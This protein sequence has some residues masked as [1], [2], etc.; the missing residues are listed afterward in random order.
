MNDDFSKGFICEFSSEVVVV[1]HHRFLKDGI[2]IRRLVNGHVLG[3]RS[4]GVADHR[5]A[6]SKGSLSPMHLR[7]PAE[8][9]LDCERK[10]R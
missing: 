6:P 2:G 10:R 1:S 7:G 4:D 3:K 9:E 5:P 8:I